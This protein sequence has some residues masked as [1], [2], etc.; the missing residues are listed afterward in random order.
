MKIQKRSESFEIW[1]LVTSIYRIWHRE[2]ERRLINSGISIMEYR[3]LR[4]LVEKGAQPMVKLAENNM[5]TQGWV[6]SLIDRLEMKGYVERLRSNMD[7]RVVNI[8]ATETGANFYKNIM[9]LH[10]EFI[11]KTLEFM[12]P[13]D[14]ASL[15]HLL[16]K[17]E[18]QLI[19]THHFV[20]SIVR[21]E[22]GE[23]LSEENFD[24]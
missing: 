17:V 11:E 15:C 3:I 6:T 19:H 2:V 9:N 14:R 23:K 16:K 8:S 13:E 4:Q 1:R 24:Q 5:I 10:E 18:D 20:D 21:P 12:E 7:R 22:M